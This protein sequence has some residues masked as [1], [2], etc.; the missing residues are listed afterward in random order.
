MGACCG[1]SDV[2]ASGGM[3][4][5]GCAVLDQFVITLMITP[6]LTMRQYENTDGQ[7]IAPRMDW[8]AAA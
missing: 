7:K 2:P 8:P 5:I 3:L 1:V 4:K 6:R